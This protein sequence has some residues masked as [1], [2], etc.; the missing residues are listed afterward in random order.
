MVFLPLGL[1]R[2]QDLL[3]DLVPIRTAKSGF[4]T[5]Y[6]STFSPRD[7]PDL[8]GKPEYSAMCFAWTELSGKLFLRGGP[9]GSFPLGITSSAVLGDFK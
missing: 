6:I 3:L 4:T 5:R 7:L 2:T 9:A 8:L 1:E